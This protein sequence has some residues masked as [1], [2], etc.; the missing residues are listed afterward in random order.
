MVFAGKFY[1]FNGV[2]WC[3]MGDSIDLMDDEWCLMGISMHLM[4]F[5]GV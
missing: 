2:W 4:V 3:L 5:D 1:G